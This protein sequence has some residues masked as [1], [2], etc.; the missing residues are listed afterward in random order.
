M[1]LNKFNIFYE[2]NWP[3]SYSGVE[4]NETKK[5]MADYLPSIPNQKTVDDLNETNKQLD[6]RIKKAWKPLDKDIKD[7]LKVCDE[8]EWP[9]K[10]MCILD[11]KSQLSE[12]ESKINPESKDKLWPWWRKEK[13]QSALLQKAWLDPNVFPGK[14]ETFKF[15]ED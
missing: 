12:F 2:M 4:N 9:E 7:A 5:T 8:L 14:W 6:R 3:E 13:V 15:T 1:N 11:I 10:N